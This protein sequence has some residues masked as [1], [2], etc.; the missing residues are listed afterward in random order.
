[1][2]SPEG[3]GCPLHGA[4]VDP[5]RLVGRRI[6]RMLTAWHRHGTDDATDPLE[7]WL[8]DDRDDFTHITTGSDWCRVHQRCEPRTR[9]VALEI[10][11]PTGSVR[12]R[13]WQGTLRLADGP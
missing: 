5:G 2:T 12:Y 9:R 4:G 6:Q 1:M 11:F 3:H 10:V 8:G 7:V 13:S